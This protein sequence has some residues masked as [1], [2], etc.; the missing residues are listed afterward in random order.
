M[1]GH[2]ALEELERG[3]RAGQWPPIRSLGSDMTAYRHPSLAAEQSVARD[4]SVAN[5]LPRAS[6]NNERARTAPPQ[7]PRPSL[8]MPENAALAPRSGIRT[9][10]GPLSALA[11]VHSA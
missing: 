4:T 2:S 10:Q 9:A 6:M 11:R 7:T 3:G 8:P 1:L 5:V